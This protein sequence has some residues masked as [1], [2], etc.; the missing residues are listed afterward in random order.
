MNSAL[1]SASAHALQSLTAVG[2][3][4]S[5][6]AKRVPFCGPFSAAVRGG[7]LD[8]LRF[9]AAMMIVLYHFGGD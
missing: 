6:G 1:W 7:M 5:Y 9:A 4:F 3:V 8:I 2:G